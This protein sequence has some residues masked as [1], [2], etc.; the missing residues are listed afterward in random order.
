MVPVGTTPQP[1]PSSPPPTPTPPMREP[2]AAKGFDGEVT[3]ALVRDMMRRKA[4]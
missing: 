2:E 1:L 4:A 3:A